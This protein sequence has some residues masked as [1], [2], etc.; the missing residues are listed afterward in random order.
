MTTRGSLLILGTSSGAGKSTVVTGICRWL[1][2]RGVSVA[3]FKAQN[4]SLNSFVTL[5][6]G[7]MGRA[8]VVQAQAARVEPEVAMNPVLLKPGTDRPE[9]AHRSGASRG[10]A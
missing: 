4:M 7:E 3:P 2:R 1:H 6:G 9:P 8:Q 5:E 10:R